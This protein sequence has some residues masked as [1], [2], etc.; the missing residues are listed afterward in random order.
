MAT[1]SD[2]GRSTPAPR[3]VKPREIDLH[4]AEPL[5]EGVLEEVRAGKTAIVTCERLNYTGKHE[6]TYIFTVREIPRAGR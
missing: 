3:E 5:L 4:L 2:M 6:S 1:A